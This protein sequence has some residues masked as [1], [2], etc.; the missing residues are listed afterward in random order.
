[1]FGLVSSE[2]A[3][4]KLFPQCFACSQSYP[5]RPW[6][7]LCLAPSPLPSVLVTGHGLGQQLLMND[8]RNLLDKLWYSSKISSALF[9]HISCPSTPFQTQ[10]KSYKIPRKTANKSE[11]SIWSKVENF[12][13]GHKRYERM[14]SLQSCFLDNLSTYRYFHSSQITGVIQFWL[15]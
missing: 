4:E 1:M 13:K 7:M 14:E 6:M 12:A 8:C 11:G 5:G 3:L 2:C 9:H 15:Q 10:E